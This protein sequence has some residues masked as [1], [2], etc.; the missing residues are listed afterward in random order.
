MKQFLDD[1]FLLENNTAK[2]L[3]H[4]Y[5]L[6]MPVIDYHCHVSPQEIAL[7]ISLDNIAEAWLGGDHYKW[8]IIR[9]C[10]VDENYITGNA[11]PREKFQKFA[12]SLPNAIG[13]PVYHWTHLELRRY[14][15]CDLIINGKNAEQI[16]EICNNKLAQSDMSVRGLLHKSNVTHICTTDDPIDNL[17]WHKYMHDDNTCEVKVYP[18]FRP[19]KVLNIESSDFKEYLSALSHVTGIEI[20]S[21]DDLH[22][23]I[24]SR[25]DYFNAMG[26]VASDH[27][28]DY[29]TWTDGC[30]EKAGVI[31][32]KVLADC[33]IEHCEVEA[34]K[35]AMML[36]LAGEYQKRNWIMQIHYGA[37]RNVNSA[38]FNKLGANTGFDCISGKD[39]SA[40]MYRFLDA[41]NLKSGLPKTILYSLNPNDDASLVTAVGSFQASGLFGKMQHGSAWWHNDTKT[42]MLQ[43]MITLASMGV[44]GSFIGMLTD[45]RSF[46][47]YPRHEYFRR[48]VCNLIGGWVE[49]GE[50]PG[51]INFL[52][53]MVQN[54]S[55]NNAMSYFGFIK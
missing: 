49:N 15:D 43:Q 11:K 9:A 10:G 16:W 53:E 32:L 54:I 20:K 50:Y 48:I 36:F 8:R 5:A 3:F 34:F 22:A 12:E 24:V 29:I 47:S 6:K 18:A 30:E 27:G 2:Q 39:C 1:D 28:L 17:E 41:V 37:V 51:D 35:A 40:E 52:G 55:Y 46:L 38:M 13:N 33:K 14:F 7:D 4:D 25:I 19:D 42:G 31:L 21:I 23:A 45:G 44:L 26:C